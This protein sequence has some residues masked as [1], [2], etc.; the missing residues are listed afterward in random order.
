M[1]KV[2][3]CVRVWRARELVNRVTGVRNART[4]RYARMLNK[5]M[6]IRTD[7]EKKTAKKMK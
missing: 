6:Y 4:H 1:R 5:R 3:A 7:D 2:R